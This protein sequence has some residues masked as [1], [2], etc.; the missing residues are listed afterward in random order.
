MNPEIIRVASMI[1]PMYQYMLTASYP[2]Q[3]ITQTGSTSGNCSG[4]ESG[5]FDTAW[6]GELQRGNPVSES[7]NE[8][9]AAAQAQGIASELILEDYYTGR[10]EGRFSMSIPEGEVSV[11]GYGGVLGT[12]CDRYA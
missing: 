6:Q 1:Q 11:A 8:K 2:T 7:P 10:V 4:Q 3:S 12:G 9:W 5:S